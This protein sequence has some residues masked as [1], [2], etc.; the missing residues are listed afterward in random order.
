M[1]IDIPLTTITIGPR[2]RQKLGDIDAL[3]ESIAHIGLLHPI[4]VTTEHALV[5]GRRRLAAYEHLG[6]ETIEARVI[7]LDD[8]LAAEID[9]NEQ[10][11]AYTIS[12]WIAIGEAREDRDR[13]KAAQR[14]SQAGGRG[15]AK[16]KNGSV[17][18][19]EPL[20]VG[21]SRD[22]TARAAGMSWPTYQKAKAVVQAARED[23]EFQDYVEEM[24]RTSKVSRVYHK[25]P[26]YARLEDPDAA[27][28]V[29]KVSYAVL[30][31]RLDRALQSL[32]PQ[33]RFL[34]EDDRTNLGKMLQFYIEW[35]QQPEEVVH[36]ADHA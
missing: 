2:F 21:D 26:A 3:A 32:L 24:D 15:N 33:I 6:R 4:I 22:I 1:L 35:L 14:Q 25:L 31:Q 36:D 30:S 19:T 16:K 11:K 5:A 29:R 12:E 20:D 18:V 34:T 9:E 8:P 23:P 28:V 17:K 27:P 10:R 13:E 7:D